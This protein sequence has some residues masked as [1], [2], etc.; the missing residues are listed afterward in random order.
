MHP[1]LLF[2]DVLLWLTL[3]INCLA[4]LPGAML[5]S[6]KKYSICIILP[7]SSLH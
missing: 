4:P 2:L 7:H 6:G 5:F 3:S 1:Y